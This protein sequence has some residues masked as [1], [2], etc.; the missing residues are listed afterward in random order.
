MIGI[1]GDIPFSVSFNGSEP[2]ILNFSELGRNGEANYEEHKRKW[3]K[4]SLE[5][6]GLGVE[7]ISLKITLRSDFGISPKK[8]LKQI[9]DHKDR[10]EVLDFILGEELVGSGSYVINSYDAGYEY[11]TNNGTVKKID[12]NINLSEY[13]EEL[14]S[15]IQLVTK[16]KENT[17][18]QVVNEDYNQGAISP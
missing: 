5:F 13:V 18:Q 9:V 16:E 1:L 2:E 8:L 15:N 12:I 11:I 6:I 4:S 17:T 14:S 3:N 10:G 7:K